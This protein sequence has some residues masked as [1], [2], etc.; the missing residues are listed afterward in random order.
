MRQ[1][2]NRLIPNE[3]TVIRYK[4]SPGEYFTENL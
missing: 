3:A 2:Y 4:D 1:E